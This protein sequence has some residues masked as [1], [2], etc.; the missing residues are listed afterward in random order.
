MKPRHLAVF[1]VIGLILLAG[2][3]VDVAGINVTTTVEAD[4]SGHWVIEAG[5]I[6]DKESDTELDCGSDTS[7]MPPGSSVRQENRGDEVWCIIEIPFTD[8]AGLHAAYEGLFGDAIQIHCLDYSGAQLIYDV[9][10]ILE[11]PLGTSVPWRVEAPGLIESNN[12]SESNASSVTWF[13]TQSTRMRINTDGGDLCPSQVL[14]LSVLVNEDGTGSG[15]LP[16]PARRGQRAQPSGGRRVGGSRVAGGGASQPGAG[17][18]TG[19]KPA[20]A[21]R[22][23]PV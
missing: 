15:T 22:M 7:D 8:V 17:R 23:S 21:G 10:L 3:D 1:A 11:E 5:F 9:E 6:Q 4:G 13:I 18:Q 14:S 19:C 16:R 12:G 20:G 2:C